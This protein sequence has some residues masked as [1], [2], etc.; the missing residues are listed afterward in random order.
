M[1][2]LLRERRRGEAIEVYRHPWIVRIVHALNAV[3]L[4]VLLTSGLQIL[5]AHPAF[6]WG[7]TS[8]FAEPLAAIVSEP[9]PDGTLRGRVEVF[10][11]RLDTTGVLG[12]SKG[13]DGAAEARAFPS[14]LT[15]PTYP[16]L[17]AGRA[18]HFAFA[19]LLVANGAVY[20]AHG[21]MSG[22]LGGQLAPTGA[23][24]R[25]LPASF[26]D[27]LRLK[28]PTGEAARQ[29]NGLQKLAYLGVIVVALP[30]ML[31]TGLAMSPTMH[32]WAPWLGDL[33]GGRQSARTMHFVTVMALVAFVAVHLAMVLAAGPVNELRAIITGWYRLKSPKEPS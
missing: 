7:E 22:R 16:D 11:A 31:L 12:V 27:H 23:D 24:L 32:A 17:G 10:G 28:F 3:C 26:V 30:V 21:L 19:W 14:W 13:S 6:Y 4:L 5:N 20:L 25:H 1:A 9:A 29:Y 8:R 18:W 2:Y 33:F 15:L